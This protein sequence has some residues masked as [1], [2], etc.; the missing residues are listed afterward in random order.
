MKTGRIC[1]I[2]ERDPE[3]KGHLGVEA[4]I[5]LYSRLAG[6]PVPYDWVSTK[7]V[8]HR[9][10]ASALEGAVGIWCVPGSPYASTTGA[11]TAIRHAREQGIPFLGTCGGFQHALM[12]YCASA[13]GLPAIHEELSPGA[14]TPLIAKLSCSLVET[15][16]PVYAVAGSFY[17]ILMGS[18]VSKEE[19]HCNYGVAPNFESVFSGTDLEFVARDAGGRVRVFR[20]RQHPFFV[21]SLFQP[22]RCGLVGELHPLVRAFLERSQDWNPASRTHS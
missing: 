20:H 13:L 7:D 11:L 22:E 10:T 21:G 15:R 17:E 5:A 12:E 8:E 18:A 1:L 9:G 16:A 19:F 14:V 6:R 4:S 2:G 3:K